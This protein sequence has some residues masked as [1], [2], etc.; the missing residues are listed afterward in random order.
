MH[1]IREKFET[2]LSCYV[3]KGESDPNK[4]S[5]S[6]SG[7]DRAH[8][9]ASLPLK[10]GVFWWNIR[11]DIAKKSEGSKI[12]FSCVGTVHSCADFFTLKVKVLLYPS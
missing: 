2:G 9:S 12:I 11:Y 8:N 10:T 1:V 4:T 5:P 7:S 3:K 6:N